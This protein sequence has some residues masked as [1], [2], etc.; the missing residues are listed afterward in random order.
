MDKKNFFINK[1][2]KRKEKENY[3]IRLRNEMTSRHVRYGYVMRSRDSWT[4]DY[5]IK[6]SRD[7]WGRDYVIKCAHVTIHSIHSL[8]SSLS[9]H[10]SHTLKITPFSKDNRKAPIAYSK[11]DSRQSLSIQLE[12]PG[13]RTLNRPVPDHE[14][15]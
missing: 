15:Y 5:V 4:C 9:L 14:R 8:P 12:A 11:L 13:V 10:T 7:S 2:I 3:V 6:Y 1:K